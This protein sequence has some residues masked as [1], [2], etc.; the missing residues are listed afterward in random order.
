MTNLLTLTPRR[1]ELLDAY[2]RVRGVT[3][4]LIEPLEPEDMVV[5]SMPDVSPTKW[6]L[7]H[8]SWFFETLVLARSGRPYTSF[9]PHYHA[10]FNSYYES[11][12]DPYP[13][14]R[15]GLLSRPTVDEVRAYRR[16]VD[17]ALVELMEEAPEELLEPLAP[18][19]AIGLQHEEQHQ[20]LLLMDVKH[21]L[22]QNPLR[23]A[24]RRTRARTR[25][26][27]SQAWIPFEGGE[28]EVGTSTGGF[29]NEG[30]RHTVVLRPFELARRPVTCGEYLAFMADEGYRRPELW[31]ADGWS[32]VQEEDW[33][34]PL[35]WEQDGQRWRVTTLGGL[36]DVEPDEPV[37]HVSYYEAQAYAAWSGQRLPSEL[38]WEHAGGT[39]SV[40]GA[41]L[42]DG[43]LHPVG[44]ADP[45]PDGEPVQIL[46]DVWEW[47][48]SPYGPYPGYVP[49]EGELGE[50]NGK[51]MVNQLVLRGGCCVTP[52]RH[53]RTTYRNFYYPH[54]RW[55]FAGIRLAR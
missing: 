36:R 47:T 22:A 52:R 6:H 31:L 19:L 40:H 35:Y 5:Q 55:M 41:L 48:E 15:R 23:P 29:D 18:V 27:A 34:A 53:I 51:F 10:L 9:H 16:H 32:R 28:V 7:A 17:Q 11:L 46:G 50:Y 21:V 33:R 44:P 30:P 45:G 54:Q 13:R 24:Y 2:R 4:A 38:E 43:A 42:E 14:A 26:A 12:G 8:T 37:C 25:A 20:E 49:F 39:A 3:E 1:E